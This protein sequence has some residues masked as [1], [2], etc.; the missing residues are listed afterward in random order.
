[1]AYAQITTV[2]DQVTHLPGAAVVAEGARQAALLGPA[3]VAIHDDRHVP[4]HG[5]AAGLQTSQRS[6]QGAILSAAAAS[7]PAKLHIV[8]LAK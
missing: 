5:A 7:G 6:V 4:G 1:M 8:S 3:A 2:I